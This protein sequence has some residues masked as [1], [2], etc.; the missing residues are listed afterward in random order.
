MSTYTTKQGDMWDAIAYELYGSTNY[1][2]K[3]MQAN[4]AH[5]DTYIFSAGVELDVP[6]LTDEEFEQTDLPPWR[7]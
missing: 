2:G 6:E 5:F 4:Q 1:T 7:E 3:L